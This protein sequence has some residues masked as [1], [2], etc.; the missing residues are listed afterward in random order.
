MP[1]SKGIRKRYQPEDVERAIR[2]VLEE[3]MSQRQA[4]L[5][6]NVP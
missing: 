2:A 5:T 4:A 1:K 3:G 6:F